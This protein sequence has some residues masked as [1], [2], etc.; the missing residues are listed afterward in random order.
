[1]AR[2]DAVSAGAGES[3]LGS[4][5]AALAEAR[6]NG[7]A[8]DALHGFAAA[9][10]AFARAKN[11]AVANADKAKARAMKGRGD[12]ETARKKTL[13]KYAD[14]A[15]SAGDHEVE[16]GNAALQGNDS[17]GA[18]E[19][20]ELAAK[21]YRDAV[22]AVEASLGEARG[23]RQLATSAQGRA[24]RAAATADQLSA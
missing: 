18:S 1:A 7:E 20:Y 23:Q 19:H 5:D 13:A 15:L 11:E 16:L 12:A 3:L 8:E 17:A 9:E 2:A 4:G 24:V 22:K 21:A 6:A 10:A 14:A